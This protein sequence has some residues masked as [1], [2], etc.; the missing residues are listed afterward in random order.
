M[1][2]RL[3]TTHRRVWYVADGLYSMFADLA[4]FADARRRWPRGTSN[5]WLYIDDAHGVG[6]T[7]A[8][9]P[10]L[11][12][13]TALARDLR[14]DR[15]RGVAE[16]VVRGRR[17]RDH[18]PGRRVAA[19][20]RAPSGGPMIFSGPV[21]PPMLGRDRRV[22]QD[23]P[24]AASSPPARQLLRDAHRLFNRSPTSS[25][26]RSSS[27][28]ETPIRFVGAGVPSVAYGSPRGCARPG[29]FVEHRR[30][31]RPSRRSAAACGS[32]S[33]RTTP[34]DDVAGVVAAARRARPA[35]RSRARAA[36][37]TD[38]R[39][40]FARQLR[41]RPEVLPSTA[42]ASPSCPS[43]GR[44]RPSCGWSTSGR[45]TT[46]TR[47]SGTR[48][49]GDR[50]TFTVDGLRS[51]RRSSPARRAA[52]GRVG[53]LTT[54]SSATAPARRRWPRSSP[55]ALW[56]D[57][58]LS[59]AEVSELVERRRRAED[60]YYLTS[61]TF[62]DGLA[63]DRGRPPLPGPQR[64]LEGGAA[65]DPAGGPRRGGR[66]R[67]RPPWCCATCRDGDDELHDLPARRGAAAHPR[68]RQ[69]GP[70]RRVQ[71]TTRSSWPG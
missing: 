33:P 3:R 15:R 44:R 52:R 4:P 21:Q 29:F 6:W 42:A 50:G 59:S 14:P 45:S 49:S 36:T 31:S 24:L 66:R 30:R 20:G 11:R 62:G 41:G 1:I 61:T 48:C 68:G 71:R 53:L 43:H 12:R 60:P 57:D 39:R 7:G 51:S 56:K 17:R 22:G 26:C 32:R 65:D 34:S 69:L 37:V 16:Q 38:L 58:M 64:G 47:W 35:P 23:P 2:E 5:L 40:A 18:L 63:A 10:R 67:R 55:T 19:A 9:R 8:A 54:T 70:R 25:A 13:S 27:H 46:S 28:A